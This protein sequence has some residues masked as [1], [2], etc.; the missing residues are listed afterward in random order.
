MVSAV[1]LITVK[2]DHQFL[3]SPSLQRKI[4]SNTFHNSLSYIFSLETAKIALRKSLIIVKCDIKFY[5]EYFLALLLLLHR[6]HYV[7]MFHSLSIRNIS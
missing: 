3:F 5:Y 4:K 2:H 7:C 1:W 6:K